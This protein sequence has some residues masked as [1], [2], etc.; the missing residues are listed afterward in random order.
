MGMTTP[1]DIHAAD[2]EPGDR[3]EAGTEPGHGSDPTSLWINDA[4]DEDEDQDHVGM[5]CPCCRPR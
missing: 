1:R 3:G 2:G 4:Y 5:D